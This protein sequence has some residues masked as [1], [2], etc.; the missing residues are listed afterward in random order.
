MTDPTIVHIRLRITKTCIHYYAVARTSC[1][2]SSC[3]QTSGNQMF[4]SLYRGHAPAY[5]SDKVVYFLSRYLY[6]ISLAG[7][8]HSLE[9]IVWL[10]LQGGLLRYRV[11]G[12]SSCL[13]LYGDKEFLLFDNC[14]DFLVR[15]IGKLSTSK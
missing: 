4:F 5:S 3:R 13:L 11:C 7:V 2:T 6:E 12:L 10:V 9:P 15:A 14:E 1:V 8:F